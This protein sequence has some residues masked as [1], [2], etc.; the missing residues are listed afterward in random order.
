[1]T[2]V[3]LRRDIA[4]MAWLTLR[5]LAG[6]RSWLWALLLTSW[7][8]VVVWATGAAVTVAP[9]AMLEV[10]PDV[11]AGAFL[12][13][14]LVP[15]V[16]AGGGYALTG[17]RL[18]PYPAT[19]RAQV[20]T[21]VY[22][23]LADVP[24]LLLGPTVLGLA[25]ALAGWVGVWAA[26]AFLATSILA[27]QTSAWLSVLAAGTRRWPLAT[28]VGAGLAALLILD[29]GGWMWSR[30]SQAEVLPPG[31][32]AAVIAGASAPR[33]IP[34]GLLAVLTVLPATVLWP[35]YQT[36]SITLRRAENDQG[37]RTYRWGRPTVASQLGPTLQVAIQLVRS[38]VRA[39]NIRLTLLSIGAVPLLVFAGD[40][41]TA[42]PET[43]LVV[44]TGLALFGLGSAVGIN[45]FSFL[46]G[47]TTLL[48]TAPLSDRQMVAG[49][50]AGF[51]TLQAA[52]TGYVFTVA[53][54]LVG[55]TSVQRWSA[56]AALLPFAIVIIALSVA[57][58]VKRPAAADHDSLRTK[59]SSLPAT[60][61]FVAWATLFAFVF[62][63]VGPA[64][65][66]GALT[67][68]V[69]AAVGWVR[70]ALR[71]LAGRRREQLAAAVRL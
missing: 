27:G 41:S 15:L 52:A 39:T 13:L 50:A 64:S 45:L 48:L 23:S 49:T 34:W 29:L 61:T 36:A 31:L 6:G 16:G 69:V 28:A 9:D 54:W 43:Q 57:W 53:A 68:A 3:P 65:P 38:M 2:R 4:N 12:T 17:E 66:A 71:V 58:S 37:P 56:A 33:D 70:A 40:D 51:A 8:T 42:A 67:I 19:V 62:V 32:L 35:L 11:A 60:V 46:A 5:E 1:M 63:L 55:A 26:A 14:V 59:V 24:V 25:G 18:A 10:F 44:L 22:S 47:G 30:L 20:L 7:V 21:G